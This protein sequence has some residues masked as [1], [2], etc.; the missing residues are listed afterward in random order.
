MIGWCKLRHIF[1]IFIL[2]IKYDKNQEFAI[3]EL[4]I[5]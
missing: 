2:F 5:E 3:S 4:H 1:H